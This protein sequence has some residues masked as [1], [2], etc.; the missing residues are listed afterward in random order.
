MLFHAEE[1]AEPALEV[2][3]F[4]MPA[5]RASVAVRR[6]TAR[7]PLLRDNREPR[8][9]GRRSLRRPCPAARLD[10]EQHAVPLVATSASAELISRRWYNLWF[11]LHPSR[12]E[13]G[14][15]AKP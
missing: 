13:K 2:A 9:G 6:R 10:P 4:V 8:P 15:A 11:R 1:H 5:G 12:T 14:D 7:Q 3:A